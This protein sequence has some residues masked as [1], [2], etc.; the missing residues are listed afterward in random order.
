MKKKQKLRL[1]PAV[2]KMRDLVD[3]PKIITEQCEKLKVEMKEKFPN[4]DMDEAIDRIKSHMIER[5][6][7]ELNKKD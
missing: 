1:A 3:F 6:T 7:E 5:Y 2:I 4:R